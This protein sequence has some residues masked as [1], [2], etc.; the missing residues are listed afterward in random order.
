M[1]A[2]QT[3]EPEVQQLHQFNWSS[4]HT[5]GKD[6]GS[7]IASMNLNDGGKARKVLRDS[8][9]AEDLVGVNEAAATIYEIKVDGRLSAWSLTKPSVEGNAVVE[10]HDCR[11]CAN[12]TQSISFNKSDANPLPPFYALKAPHFDTADINLKD[13]K[14]RTT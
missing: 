13:G 10:E 3:L 11:V 9:L 6:G 7:A 4:G 2:L 5:K 14:Q 12:D 8:E 1:H